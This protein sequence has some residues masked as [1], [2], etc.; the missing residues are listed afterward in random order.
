MTSVG[1]AEPT[2]AIC[3]VEE[4]LCDTK[5]AICT[6]IIARLLVCRGVERLRQGSFFDS[7]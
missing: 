3:F 5:A 6:E 1:G 7:D 2:S 4:C